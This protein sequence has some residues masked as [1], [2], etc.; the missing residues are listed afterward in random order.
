MH[1]CQQEIRRFLRHYS[2]QNSTI[3][4]GLSGGPDSVALLRLLLGESAAASLSLTAAHVNYGLRGK[5]SQEDEQFCR[6]LCD[7]LGV[8]LDV[9][10]VEM[11]SRRG[12]LQQEARDIRLDYFH[13]VCRER[14]CDYIALGHNR[15]D[16]VETIVMNL[17]RGSGTFGLGGMNRVGGRIIRP[18]L[19]CSREEI[20]DYLRSNDFE[21]RVDKTNLG[22][23]YLRNRVRN[24]LL[25]LMRRVFDDS[26][27]RSIHR[28]GAIFIEHE[29]FLRELGDA[30]LDNI[31]SRTA[32]GKIVLDLTHFRQY[33]PLIKRV[34]IALCFERVSGSLTGLDYAAVER[35]LTAIE[36]GAGK[37]DLKYDV[38]AE[39]IGDR[40]YFFGSCPEVQSVDVEVPGDTSLTVHGLTL[41]S[42]IL[43][44]T[45]PSKQELV[46]GE[47]SRVYLD[48]DRLPTELMVRSWRRGDRFTPLGMNGSKTLADFFTDRKIDR[49][50]REEIPILVGRGSDEDG[51]IWV[52]G[53][54][55]A[56]SYKLREETKRIVK[57][58]VKSNQRV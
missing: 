53:H 19:D 40:L 50:L 56:D 42:E 58:E 16:N 45:K 17:A 22:G 43:T 25:P 38:V 48:A 12:N 31:S 33:H 32:F 13:E 5:D 18:L 44:G 1:S 55:I 46:Q 52:I 8:Q 39:V 49:P 27:D 26:V 34:L 7:E 29:S 36:R 23:K 30:K 37:A 24:E 20:N 6:E 47:S 11:D 41:T 2:I 28:A 10:P 21:F 3:L 14:R 54:E 9:L 57:L 51:I 15:D 35:V 4:V